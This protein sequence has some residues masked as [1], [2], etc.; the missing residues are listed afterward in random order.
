MNS[1]K[2]KFDFE[3]F[4]VVEPA[5]ESVAEI[6]NNNKVALFA[7]QG[8]VNSKIYENTMKSISREIELVGVGCPDLVLAIEDGHIDDCLVKKL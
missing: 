3:I 5:C 1:A 6:T 7:T 4:G 2:D 8:T